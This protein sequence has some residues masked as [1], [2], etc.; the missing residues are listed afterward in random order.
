MIQ[1]DKADPRKM[2]QER[3]RLERLQREGYLRILAGHKYAL[4]Y[5][6]FLLKLQ[7]WMLMVSSIIFAFIHWAPISEMILWTHEWYLT[8]VKFLTFFL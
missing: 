3:E 1:G 8:F 7:K 4:L 5:L 2:H 6:L